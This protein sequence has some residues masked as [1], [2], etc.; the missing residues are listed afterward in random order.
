M[1]RSWFIAALLAV[2][3][4]AFTLAAVGCGG[5]TEP[6]A[7]GET[8]VTLDRYEERVVEVTQGDASAV[9]WTSADEAVVTVEAGNL[10]AQGVG[11]TTVTASDGNTEATVNVTV[12]DSGVRPVI[13]AEDAY[14]G[15]IGIAAELS[16]GIRYNGQSVQTDAQFT[17]TV[18]DPSVAE[19]SGTAVTGKAVGNTV[20]HFSVEYK[21]LTLT[22]TAQLTVREASFVDLGQDEVE[23]YAAESDM[24]PTSYEIAASVTYN[25]VAVASPS[26]IYEVVSGTEYVSLQG[27]VVSAVAEGIAEVEVAYAADPD[28]SAVLTVNVLPNYDPE[29]FVYNGIY[30]VTLE[31]YDGEVGGRTGVTVYNSGTVAYEGTAASQAW[32]HHVDVSFANGQNAVEIYQRGYKYLAYDLYYTGTARIYIGMGTTAEWAPVNEYV[33]REWF[34]IINDGKITNRF[35]Q[36]DWITVV[37]DLDALIQNDFNA[38]TSFF[39]CVENSDQTAYFDNVR[40]YLDDNFLPEEQPLTYTQENGY[41]QAEERE[42]VLVAQADESLYAPYTE[43]V[44]GR[45]GVY[46]YQGAGS[47][48]DSR[49]GVLSSMA[50][51]VLSGINTLNSRGEYLTFDIYADTLTELYISLNG[52]DTEM[53]ITPGANIVGVAAFEGINI[54]EGDKQSP[55]LKTGV[56]QTVSIA[57]GDLIDPSAWSTQML[58]AVGSTNDVVYIDNVRFYE[59]DSFI[60][61]EYLE[62]ESD[63]FEALVSYDESS[64]TLAAVEGGFGGITENVYSYTNASN[65]YGGR[66][67]FYNHTEY[68]GKYVTF[69]LYLQEG[70]TFVIN[71]DYAYYGRENRAYPDFVKVYDAELQQVNTRSG[72][73]SLP[74]NEW[75]TFVLDFSEQTINSDGGFYISS[76][77]E[78]DSMTDYITLPLVSDTDPTPAGVTELLDVTVMES[79]A[80]LSSVKEG[81]F[82]GSILYTSTGSYYDGAIQF[83]DAESN[84]GSYVAAGYQFI[85]FDIYL[86]D[87][88][89]LHVCNWITAGGNEN[90]LEGDFTSS[91]SASPAIALI[92]DAD[93]EAA[94]ISR[95]A[96]YHVVI[97]TPYT[98]TPDWFYIYVGI[99]GTEDSPA[100][101]YIRNVEF[102]MSDPYVKDTSNIATLLTYDDGGALLESVGTYAG[103]DGVYRYT[104]LSNWYSGRLRFVNPTQHLGKYVSFKFRLEQAGSLAMQIQYDMYGG[105]GSA[106]FPDFVKFYVDGEETDVSGGFTQNVWYTVVIDLTGGNTGIDAGSGDDGLYFTTNVES[107]SVDYIADLVISDTDPMAAQ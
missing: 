12:R 80:T 84:T 57:Y 87:V 102:R 100:E 25:G 2:C 37:Y 107:Q 89:S 77:V 45:T 31:E 65:W 56:W 71:W 70:S 97:P 9:T 42:F 22:D 58:I 69:K 101:A 52:A 49:L 5:S 51:S 59:D 50:S 35:V 64:V 75:L 20:L 39:F 68:A 76:N 53:H 98:A 46:R 40:Y 8:E 38:Y 91:S 43:D 36:N 44:G 7:L 18:E 67:Q 85:V 4:A 95:G 94:N 83:T 88:D 72:G 3:I 29:H 28:I 6:L 21:G 34:R 27:N 55:V 74:Q 14:T 23:I 47:Y 79:K 19:V 13:A 30:D 73:F 99:V 63:P 96:W 86:S 54:I 103:Q 15:Y 10:I 26:F 81:E 24:A 93:G 17:V 90:H 62:V 61:E 48:W 66:L 104:N 92:Y 16:L 41:L 32:E 106:V 11:Q 82:A 78:S 1:K 33:H 60:P 105:R